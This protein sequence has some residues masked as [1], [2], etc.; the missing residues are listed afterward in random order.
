[1]LRLERRLQG[2][3]LQQRGHDVEWQGA[4]FCYD[5]LLF[6]RWSGA[7]INHAFCVDNSCCLH[8]IQFQDLSCVCW[9]VA[10]ALVHAVLRM[11]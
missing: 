3:D 10:S 11:R 9:E 6:W 8:V 2:I 7:E 1:M 5:Q 4:M